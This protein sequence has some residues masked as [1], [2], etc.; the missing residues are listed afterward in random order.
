[1]NRRR[2][3]LAILGALA[4]SAASGSSLAFAARRRPLRLYWFIADGMR[5]DPGPWPWD[6]YR[7]ARKGAYPNI[8]KMME[9]GSYGY[10]LP[11]FP[12]HTPSNFA[13]LL[14]GSFPEIHGVSDGPM[15]PEGAPL[16][17]PALN[18]FSSASRRVPSIW[19][20]LEQKG[21][22]A[23]VVS[24]P[25]STPPEVDIG[26]VVR[27]RWGHWGADFP[28]LIFDTIGFSTS[29]PDDGGN[30]F[31][32]GR[33]LR[34]FPR[35]SPAKGW[36]LA[37]ESRLPPLE[38][39]MLGYGT[40]VYALLFDH[41]AAPAASYSKVLIS[42][43]KRRILATLSRDGEWSAWM[44]VDLHWGG[45]SIPTHMKICRVLLKPDGGV[46]IRI[47]Y[48]VLNPTVVE[49]AG[50]A[51]RL[52]GSIGPMVDFPDNWPAQLNRRPEEMP[53]LL[54]ETRMA[55]DWHRRAV[56]AVLKAES[57]DVL[58][59]DTYVPNQVL[60]SRWWLRHVD[61]GSPDFA[62]SHPQSREL[63]AE[64]L[65]GVYAGLDAIL[66]AA[67]KAAG[68]QTY[69]VLSS[70]HGII[71]IKRELRINNLLA[72]EGLLKAT[73][74]ADGE[75]VAVDWGR[76]QAAYLQML[77]VCVRPEGLAGN[78]KRGRGREYLA[79]RRRVRKLLERLRGD[80]GE[81]VFDAV[82][83]WE[84]AGKLRLPKDRVPDLVLATRPG[85]DLSETL[86]RERVVFARPLQSGYKHSTKA[87][88][89]RA[90]WTPF[91]VM[92]PGIK[93]GY[94]I[95]APIRHVD[96]APTLMSLLGVQVPSFM[97][98]RVVREILDDGER[99]R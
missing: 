34:L 17:A 23:A 62:S 89:T 82:V 16:A 3:V 51:G 73:V 36:R 25:G 31:F 15:R 81:R 79:L 20:F 80:D 55:L 28:A 21:F 87:E 92:G 43:D 9:Q 94:A 60:E 52:E 68:P 24:V 59:Q 50:L 90:L 84:E 19:N 27:G 83:P 26:S 47:L 11:A 65:R 91:I 39:P 74:G 93:K 64:D 57:P 42:I 71:P 86:D 77:G 53:V 45:I 29:A 67:L 54:A 69:V 2:A 78:W 38:I 5:A 49:P 32:A 44:P 66:G 40:T 63:A 72:R 99:R 75:S 41:G 33:R 8:K 12:S 88:L 46:E 22:K 76:S 35:A 4:V 97:Q 14:T 1:M 6:I 30:G 13:T 85:Y 56:G 61:P 70:D 95:S 10:S 37:P 96:Q 58:I 7:L 98:G 48:D 18:G